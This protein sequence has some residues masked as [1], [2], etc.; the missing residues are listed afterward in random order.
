MVAIKF[1][2]NSIDSTNDFQNLEKEINL[3]SKLKHPN[4]VG[5]FGF[6]INESKSGLVLEY[7]FNFKNFFF[8]LNF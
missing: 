2:K 5:F 8:F 1:F 6:I 3:I 4:I 7:C